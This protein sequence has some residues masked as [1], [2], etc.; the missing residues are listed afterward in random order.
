MK[1]LCDLLFEF[2]NE[3]RLNILLELRKT[4][5][6]LSRISEKF[7]FTVPETARNITRLSEANLIVKN[8][9]SVFHLTPFGEEALN[10]LPGFK[11]LSKNRKYFTL[12]ALPPELSSGVG[13]LADSTFVK[14][15]ATTIYNFENM[16]REAQEFIW[17]IIDQIVASALPLIRE[18]VTRGVE[19]KKILPRTADIPEGILTLAN[20]PVFERA[21]RAQKLES[22]YLDRIDV[23]IL[24]SEKEVA[25]MLFPNLEGK[26]DFIGFQTKNELAL[27]WSK[28]LFSYYWNKA[29]R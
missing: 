22:R 12:S 17:V 14:E 11:F 5:M 24:L 8:V 27:N 21:A 19:F 29:K 13:A 1:E 7:N 23:C 10:L 2:S 26:F 16:M 9:D 20:D 15:V 4:P 6:K 25:A 3:D 28:S 18:A